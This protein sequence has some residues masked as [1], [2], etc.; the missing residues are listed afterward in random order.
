M[1]DDSLFNTSGIPTHLTMTQ[2]NQ[3]N[4]V[5]CGSLATWVLDSTAPFS[6]RPMRSR[7]CDDCGRVTAAYS[8]TAEETGDEEAPR[9]SAAS[10]RRGGARPFLRSGSELHDMRRKRLTE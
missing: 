1:A 4:C 3:P 10:G 6:D 7:H 8:E 9:G 5:E 2:V